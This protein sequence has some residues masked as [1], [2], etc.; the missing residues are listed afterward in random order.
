MLSLA[1]ILRIEVYW[2][3]TQESTASNFVGM[4][5]FRGEFIQVIYSLLCELS[6]S[7]CSSSLPSSSSSSSRNRSQHDPVE[8]GFNCAIS[9]LWTMAFLSNCLPS[10]SSTWLT[11]SSCLYSIATRPGMSDCQTC[12]IPR[13]Q[14]DPSIP[15][16][17]QICRD[18][19]EKFRSS[20]SDKPAWVRVHEPDRSLVGENECASRYGISFVACR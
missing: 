3:D 14:A 19:Q 15:H 16:W 5:L 8:K 12:R 10:S 7:Q 1:P 20:V 17:R 9:F 11:V 4:I 13:Y 6:S 18:I 2:V